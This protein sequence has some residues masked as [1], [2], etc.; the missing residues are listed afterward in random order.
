GGTASNIVVGRIAHGLMMMGRTPDTTNDEIYFNSIKAGVDS[1]PP[2]AKIFLNSAEF[3]SN[4]GGIENLMMLARFYPK[5]P[6]YADKT[7]LSVKGAF[8]LPAKPD[9]SMENMRKSVLN[10]QRALG[11]HK[12]F[13]LF[14]PARIDRNMA[15][16]VILLKEGHFAHI[17]LSECRADTLRRAH[18]V[19]PVT[20]AEIEV[21][22]WVYEAE[23]KKVV[24]TAGGS[25]VSVL[26][27]SPLGKG[28]FSGRFSSVADLPAGDAS[29]QDNLSLVSALPLLAAEKGVTPAQLANAWVA[30]LGAHV[31]LLPGFSAAARTLENCAAGDIALFAKEIEVLTGIADAGGVKG[32]RMAGGPEVDD[33][34]G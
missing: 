2:G 6:E 9:C 34:W 14:Q 10:I 18:L 12:K 21:I 33:L 4:T 32:D 5:Y 30:A 22:L 1:L 11:P 25:G 13:D 16:L 24:A 17:G 31:V 15:N 7:F 19:H 29:L 27:Y 26:A 3:Y 28:F 8:T 20:V 23:H